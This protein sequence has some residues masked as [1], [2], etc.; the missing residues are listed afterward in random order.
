MK[1]LKKIPKFKTEDAEREFWSKN[2]F[3]DFL[4]FSKGVKAKFPNLK[5]STQTISLRLPESLLADIKVLAN[6]QDIPYQSYIKVLL[7]EKIA[8]KRRN[9]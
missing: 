8:E 2:D 4:D 3:T 6:R 7:S 9:R 1:T 5:P